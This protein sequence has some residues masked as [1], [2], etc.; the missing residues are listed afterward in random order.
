MK[1]IGVTSAKRSPAM[2]N[3]PTFA[4]AGLTGFEANSWWAILA[5]AGTPKEIIAR[6]NAEVVKALNNAALRERFI[7]LGAGSAPR[8]MKRSRKAALFKAFT[9]SAL[10]RAMISFGVPAGARMA[11]QELASK[12][13]SPASAKVGTLGMAGERFALVTP[14]AFISVSYTHLRAH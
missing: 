10:S 5:P 9:T 3:V 13:V 7:G 12:P 2:P 8:P 4:E 14:I 11:H 1:A 6:L